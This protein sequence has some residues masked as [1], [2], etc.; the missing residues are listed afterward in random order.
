[1]NHKSK[2]LLY[3]ALFTGVLHLPAYY[4]QASAQP[5]PFQTQNGTFAITNARLETVTQGTIEDGTIVIEGGKIAALGPNV[6]APAGATVIDG[7]GMWVVPGMI[8]GGTRIGLLEIG[9]QPETQD[10]SE[11]GPITPQMRA[12]TA[13]NPSSVHIPVTR[14]SGV[15][16]AL[17]VPQGGIFPGQAALITLHGYTPEQLFAGFE[18]VVLRFPPQGRR[19]PRD[20]RSEEEVE[21]EVEEAMERL[22]TAWEDAVLFSRIRESGGEPDYQPEMEVLSRAVTG[23]RPLLVEVNQAR[24]ILKTLEWLEED[25]RQ[26]ARVILTGVAEGWRVADK[27]AAANLPVITGPVLNLP[28]RNS[29]RYSRA[30]ENAALL[31]Q[32]GV[33]VALRTM[34]TENARNLPF[35]AGFAAAFGEPFGFSRE[36]A[37]AAVTINPAR[38][39][40]V[41]D[42]LG[43]LEVGKDATLF[44]ADGDPFEPRTQIQDLF[45][46]GTRIPIASRQTLLYEEYLNRNPGL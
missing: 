24:D 35:H 13:I 26:N 14:V 20:R 32:A 44:L 36:A 40:G 19:G 1:M 28:T 12:L 39:F 46:G 34:E 45:I 18:G 38:I 16:T 6:A 33:Q 4:I 43:S 9:S 21:K 29:D 25:N 30:Y 37:L 15:T 11:I 7:T 3:L 22:N 31:H 8:D 27:I 10:Y 5:L 42:R 23:E 41:D 2:I 17:S